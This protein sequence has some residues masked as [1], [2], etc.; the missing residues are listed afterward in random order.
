MEVG[1]D[2]DYMFFVQRLSK[3]ARREV[4]SL[5]VRD[6][7]TVSGAAERLGISRQG[8]RR[9]LREVYPA[10]R[11]VAR[12][13]EYILSDGSRAARRELLRIAK[14]EARRYAAGLSSLLRALGEG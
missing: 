13:V 9:V 10:D 8:L 14:E 2:G 12:A 1:L 5:V 11:T 4:L 3:E 7:G 6:G